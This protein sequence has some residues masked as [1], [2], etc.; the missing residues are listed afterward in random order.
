[1][2]RLDLN[3]ADAF[4]DT[5]GVGERGVLRD[6]A[7]GGASLRYELFE[8][9]EA[10]RP[11]WQGLETRGVFSP[12]QRYDWISALTEARGIQGRLAIIAVHEGNQAVAILPLVVTTRFGLKSARIVGWD[13][14]N[15][16]WIGMDRAFA[17]RLHGPLLDQLL[18]GV[19]RV[20]VADLLVLHSQP[21]SWDGL[22]NPFL[23]LPHQPSPD[24]FY[25]ASLSEVRLNAKRIRNIERGRRR[26][27]EAMGTVRLVRAD[28]AEAIDTIH[29]EFLRQR[30]IR[31]KEMGVANIFAEEGLRRFFR[32]ATLQGLGSPRPAL[33]MHA[34]YAGDEI[35]AT[36]V[37]SFSGDHYAQ[38][39]NSTTDGPAAKYSLMGLLMF[40]LVEELRR[41]GVTSIDMGLGDFDYK[42][43]WTDQKVSHDAVLALSPMGTLAAG[44]LLGLRAAKRAI[45]QNPTLWRFAT[46]VRSLLSRR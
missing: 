36:S 14:S 43:D 2:A 42:L 1:M 22:V 7:S 3:T 28:T 31:F 40:D 18:A 20:S 16:D 17:R 21:E 9:L 15:G 34:L 41:D 45:K 30:G 12:Y 25:A 27:E 38:Y 24:H 46:S 29:A 10:A 13:V 5:P 6:A 44:G 4:V 26:L 35:V 11:V 32:I 39:I 19:A 37:G 23:A 8:T 33:A